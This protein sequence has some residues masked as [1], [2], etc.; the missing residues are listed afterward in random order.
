MVLLGCLAA[1]AVSGS[2]LDRVTVDQLEQRVAAESGRNDTDLAHRLQK[3]ELTQRLSTARLKKLQAALPGPE[4]RDALM[5]MGDLSAVLDPPADEIPADAAP[6]LAEQ[7][8]ILARAQQ[9]SNAPSADLMPDFDATVTLT[10]FRNLKYLTTEHT[11]PIP[12]VTPVPLMLDRDIDAVNQR[13]GRVFTTHLSQTGT[14]A[15]S[16]ETGVEDSEGLYTVLTNVRQDMRGAQPE[17]LRWEQ[18]PAGK[19]AVFRFSMDR[20]HARFPIR[21]VIDPSPQRGFKG[22]VGYRAEVAL[23]PATGAIYRFILRAVVDPGQHLLRTDVVVELAP[24]TVNGETFLC[25]LRAVSIA[26]TQSYLD[27]YRSTYNGA[28][29]GVEDIRPLLHLLDVEFEDYR[30]GKSKPPAGA[31]PASLEAF[32]QARGERV[33]AVQLEK[34][35]ADLAGS[36]DHEA[37]E[38][39]GQLYLTERLTRERSARI[40]D[41]LPGKASADALLALKDLAEFEDLPRAD[42]ADGPAPDLAAQGKM[43]VSAVEF[44]SKVTQRMPDLF[45]ARELARFEDLRVVR[46]VPQLFISKVKPLAMVDH[47]A[48]MVHFREGQEVVEAEAKSAIGKPVRLGLNTKGTFGPILETV[49]TDV[50]KAKIG[51]SH[52]EQGPGGRLAVFRYAVPEADSH[53]TVRFCCYMGEDGLP[54]SYEA[55]P[56]YHGEV[57]IDPKTGAVLRLVLKAEV[58]SDA[59]AL[60]GQEESPL[61]HAD[62]LEE[63]GAVDIAGRQYIV[64]QRAVSLM[65]SWTLGPDGSMKLG[66]PKAEGARAAKKAL[67]LMEFSRVNAINEAVFRDYHVFRSEVRLVADP[68]DAG[69][70]TPKK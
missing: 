69:A 45:A 61:L 8:Q 68:G 31:S 46:G 49:T 63:Y 26:V 60:A 24:A 7:Q 9:A 53:F 10:R 2:A 18:G 6:T 62:V 58:W 70:E 34:V 1:A 54:S 41:R 64:P 29:M 50:L 13:Q 15:D 42:L 27:A 25:P 38:R 11:T 16:V 5:S 23:D 52:W 66:L 56:G 67:E 19:L 48:S 57:A 65:T 55:K 51:W 21:T 14:P 37:A 20:D 33:D 35:V 22:D 32:I 47:S 39:L 3:L 40:R 17:W 4:S 30:A 43:I 28:L 12:L 36:K 44:V 59:A